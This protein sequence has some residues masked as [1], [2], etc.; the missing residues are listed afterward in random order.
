MQRAV[1]AQAQAQQSTSVSE[2]AGQGACVY[3]DPL[4]SVAPT[5]RFVHAPEKVDAHESEERVQQESQR[6]EQQGGQ[7]VWMQAGFIDLLCPA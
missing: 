6:E 5:Q 7:Q 2:Q 4:C 1:E 3:A